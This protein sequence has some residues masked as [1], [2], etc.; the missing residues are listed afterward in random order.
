[1]NLPASEFTVATWASGNLPAQAVA[2][3][4]H[5]LEGTNKV[6]DE[7]GKHQTFS[8]CFLLFH[9]CLFYLEMI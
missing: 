3:L 4:S 6:I 7:K 9:H 8:V 1:M 2:C 5:L